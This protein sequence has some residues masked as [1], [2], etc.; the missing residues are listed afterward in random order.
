VLAV[1]RLAYTVAMAAWWLSVGIAITGRR[2]MFIL[3]GATFFVVLVAGGLALIVAIRRE[4][5]RRQALEM[6]FM[7]FTHDLKTSLARVQLQAEGLARLAGE[8][9]PHGTRPAAWRHLATSASARE[10]SL[11]P[12]RTAGCSRSGLM[13]ARPSSGS[14]STGRSWL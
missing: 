10:L 14:P 3:E 6:F 1:V 11:R 2:T 9:R 13:S 5:Q 12:S 7:P 8:Q 4:H